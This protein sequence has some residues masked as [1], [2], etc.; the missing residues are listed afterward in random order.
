[1][2]RPFHDSRVVLH[3]HVEESQTLGII[4]PLQGRVEI[5]KKFLDNLL[6]VTREGGLQ[7]VLTV[8]YFEDHSTKEV[9]AVLEAP[10]QD[11]N[12]QTQLIL[13]RGEFSRSR[14]LKIGVEETKGSAEV[15]FLCD[16]D[17][18]V[19]QDFL[20]RCLASPILGR[21]VRFIIFVIIINY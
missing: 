12:L 8:I 21:Q 11:D 1:M 19:T 9:A 14:A 2:Q 6:Q 4:V 20:L 18:L 3:T 10:R 13:L 17:L 7:V 5:L 15:V 16:V